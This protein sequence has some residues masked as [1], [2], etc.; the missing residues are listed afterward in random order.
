MDGRE[1]RLAHLE[2]LGKALEDRGFLIEV[3][4]AIAKPYLTVADA[5]QPQLNERVYCEQD[6]GS[7]WYFCWPWQ[8]LIGVAD[9]LA[10]AAGEIA[11]VIQTAGQ[12][13]K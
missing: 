10:T 1:Q 4:R 8:A 12:A 11:S 7:S 3:A 13:A 9:D 2:R 6:Q 5:G